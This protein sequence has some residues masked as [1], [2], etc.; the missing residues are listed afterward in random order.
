MLS[1][2]LNF[3]SP[4]VASKLNIGGTLSTE[5]LAY[6]RAFRPSAELEDPHRFAGRKKQVAKLTDALAEPKTVLFIYGQ[7]GLGKSSLAVQMSRIAQGDVELLEDLDL[8]DRALPEGERFITLYVTCSDETSDFQGLMRLLINAVEGLKFEQD[9]ASQ[10]KY[11]LVEKSTNTK[12]SFKI[13]GR[14]TQMK[15]TTAAGERDT[16]GMSLS[17]QLEHL[18]NTIT[19]LTGERV[20]F[21]IDELDRLGGVP[22]LASFL[23]SYST[24]HLK[25]LLVGIASNEAELL[26]DKEGHASLTRQLRRAKVE[27]MSPIELA[28]IVER[29][30]EYL[31]DLGYP[32][33]F[34]EAAKDELVRIASG[35]PW[36]VHLIGQA[37][38]LAV[39]DD[40]RISMDKSDVDA[41]LLDLV[42]ME[43]AQHF[44]DLFYTAVKDSAPREIVLRLMA[45]QKTED[46]RTSSVYPQA[47]ALGVAAPANYLGHLKNPEYGAVLVASPAQNQAL[48]RFSDEM[49]KAYVR[50]RPSLNEGVKLQVEI[51]SRRVK[52]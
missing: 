12:V 41:A 17:V 30:G 40:G 37:A 35:F 16:S 50:I 22:G 44:S 24:S 39:T 46:I 51:Q 3:T 32:I 33:D 13:F 49:F 47:K 43:L 38:L 23:K 11:R 31:A 28:D 19:D 14:D 15:Y 2:R 42:D 1:L 7:R 26:R 36:F 48:Y 34:A 25:F 27:P 6:T 10:E 8:K 45:A 5:R 9:K 18:S 21:I 52:K 4:A 29:T 20:L